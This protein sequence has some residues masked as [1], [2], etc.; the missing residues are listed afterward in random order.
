M[1][2]IKYAE[3]TCS[4]ENEKQLL[5]FMYHLLKNEM[6]KVVV[7]LNAHTNPP[8]QGQSLRVPKP[9][10]THEWKSSCSINLIS[11]IDPEVIYSIK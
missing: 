4:T 7:V 9:S 10:L 3:V 5:H 1:N 6:S 11:C 2:Y 8:I